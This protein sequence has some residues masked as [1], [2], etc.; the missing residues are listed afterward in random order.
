MKMDLTEQMNELVMKLLHYFITEK[1]YAPIILHG[2]QNEIWLENLEG[3]YEIVRI[4]TDYIHNDEQLEYDLLKTKQIARKIKQKTF[5]FSMNVISIFLNIGDNVH[6]KE[7]EKFGNIS[8]VRLNSIDDLRKQHMLLEVFPDITKET[9]FK[10][11]GMELFIKITTD[12]SKKNEETAREAEDLFKPKKPVVTMILIALN[13]ILFLAM[14]VFGK[15]STHVLTLYRFGA[16]SKDAILM[17][18]YY[19]LITSAFLHIGVVHLLCNMYSLYV[20]GPQLEGFFGKTKFLIIYLFS[21]IAGNLLSMVFPGNGGLSAGASGAIFG[22]L[23][24][25]VYFGY[26]YR[27]YLG[28]VMKSQ[29][30]PLI[31]LN[32]VVGFLSPGIN[33]AAH[34]GGLIGG[35]L[36]TMAVGVAYKSS[37]SEKVNGW[38]LTLIYVSFLV[39]MGFIGL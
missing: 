31:I 18:E 28:T 17:G 20:L 11:E 25:L 12:I 5:S 22:L 32:L 33:N 8:C 26:H 23:G 39:Y 29:I 3:D 16:F 2:A 13:L 14:Y 19:R 10:E 38:I 7:E 37:S 24:S 15:G 36:M 35:V 6:L 30:I 34:I 1:E 27:V 9:D 4:V 21:A